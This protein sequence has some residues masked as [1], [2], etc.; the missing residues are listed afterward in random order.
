MIRTQGWLAVLACALL[1]L[2]FARAPRPL[3]QRPRPAS[4]ATSV[5]VG[6]N[7]L[8]G[9]RARV[10]RLRERLGAAPAPLATLRRN[11]FEFHVAPAPVAP[12][13]S[14]PA[15]AFERER[16]DVPGRPEMTLVGMAEDPPASGNDGGRRTAGRESRTAVVAS[17]GQL[18]FLRE[19]ERLLGRYLAV[20]ILADAVELRDEAGS[21]FTLTLK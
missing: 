12:R 21:G 16:L 10:G 13:P 9:V 7:D 8:D 20:R 3:P 14:P 11:P 18:Y 4:P 2:W 17:Q 1:A 15:A 19:G 5:D 6:V